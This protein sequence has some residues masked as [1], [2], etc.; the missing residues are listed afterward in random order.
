MEK[1]P[2]SDFNWVENYPGIGTKRK[3][4]KGDN[5]KSQ[6]YKYLINEDAGTLN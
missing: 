2:Q 6:Y 3:A 4:E 5:F 1:L